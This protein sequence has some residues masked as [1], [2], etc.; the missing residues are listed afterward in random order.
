MYRR[1]SMIGIVLLESVVSTISVYIDKCLI[2]K[3]ISRKD[4]F[5][6]MCVSMIPF[7]AIMMFVEP[8]KFQIN[9]ITIGLLC[10]F[11]ILRYIKQHTVVGCLT[12][13]NPYESVTYTSLGLI[14]AFIVDGIL[15][16]RIITI[17][18]VIAIILALVGAFIIADVKLKIK[19]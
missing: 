12:Y 18:G 13:L 15:E 17:Y 4:Y 1:K 14:I 10:I 6:Y 3:V 2:N 7:A 11:M 19:A 16:I 5:F 8:I 9:I